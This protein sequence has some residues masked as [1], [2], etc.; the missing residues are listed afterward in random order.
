MEQST[1]FKSRGTLIIRRRH[2][3]VVLFVQKTQEMAGE[4][5]LLT[6]SS[7]WSG[8]LRLTCGSQTQKRLF[9]VIG[10]LLAESGPFVGPFV[11]RPVGP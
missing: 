2:V 3:K 7:C 9:V 11:G 4:P 5:Q 8:R 10:G 1:P 6:F